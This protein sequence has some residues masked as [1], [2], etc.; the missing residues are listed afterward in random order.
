MPKE[1]PEQFKQWQAHVKQVK[2]EHPSRKHREI[3]QMAKETFKRAPTGGD[4]K[5]TATVARPQGIPKTQG[6]Q[7]GGERTRSQHPRA[8]VSMHASERAVSE[9]PASTRERAKEHY[10]EAPHASNRLHPSRDH[11]GHHSR[12]RE[13]YPSRSREQRSE[14]DD[15]VPSNHSKSH[16]SHHSEVVSER[17]VSEHD[18][19]SD[20]NTCKRSIH[21][22]AVNASGKSRYVSEHHCSQQQQQQRPHQSQ[23]ASAHRGVNQPSKSHAKLSARAEKPPRDTLTEMLLSEI[24]P[25]EIIEETQAE[26]TQ[27]EHDAENDIPVKRSTR[28]GVADEDTAVEEVECENQPVA[29]GKPASNRPVSNRPVSNRLAPAEEVQSGSQKPV[30]SNKPTE[31]VIVDENNYISEGK[32][33]RRDF[34]AHIKHFFTQYEYPSKSEIRD[35]CKDNKIKKVDFDQNLYTLVTDLLKETTPAE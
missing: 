7:D 17:I 20:A 5:P 28:T 34:H 3:L 10:S 22:A 33:I 30:A 9:N 13:R 21:P 2:T 23:H 6:K 12:D 16:R 11:E 32:Y 24:P 26:D 29:A 27:V 25:S 4:S 18:R 14:I 19:K 31:K 15:R 35:F 1:V 8:I